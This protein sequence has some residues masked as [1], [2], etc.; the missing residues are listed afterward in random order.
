MTEGLSDLATRVR[1]LRESRGWSLANLGARAGVDPTT[2]WKI[3]HG[4]TPNP[5]NETLVKISGALGVHLL[6]L[7]GERPMPP[8]QPEVVGGGVKLPVVRRRVHA[9][10]ETDWGDTGDDYW[11][12]LR[13]KILYPRVQA[14]IV[15]GDC[16]SPHIRTGDKVLFDPDRTPVNG[17][18]V[19]V[20]TE[21]GHTLLK[22]FRVGADG[23]AFLRSADGQEMRPNGAKVEGVV[24]EVHRGA[25]RDPEA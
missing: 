16:M 25:I 14:A 18:M 8:R 9:G 22:W 11:V 1:R 21:D 2:I 3:E 7:T 17:Q 12:P 15:D 4:K 6:E 13:F 5:G 23:R 19:V 10:G 20:T 24:M